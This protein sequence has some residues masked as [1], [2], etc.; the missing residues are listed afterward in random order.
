M[1]DKQEFYNYIDKQMSLFPELLTEYR[2]EID[3]WYF[4]AA[5]AVSEA[6]DIRSLV[7]MDKTLKA[8]DQSTTVGSNDD[9]YSVEVKC[10]LNGILEIESAFESTQEVPLGNIPVWLETSGEAKRQVMLDAQGKASVADLTPGKEY[11][12]TVDHQVTQADMDTLFSH[13]DAI[14]ADLLAWLEGKWQGFKPQWEKYFSTSA[15]ALALDMVASFADGIWDAL[16]ALWD[17]IGELFELLQDPEKALALIADVGNDVVSAIKAA[18]DLA[19]KALLFASDE[20][21]LYLFSRAAVLY[22][23]MLPLNEIFNELASL[24]GDV[25]ANVLLA[26]LGGVVISLVATPVVGLAYFSI[27]IGTKLKKYLGRLYILIEESLEEVFALAEKLMTGSSDSLKLVAVNGNKLG[28][29]KN[30]TLLLKTENV[31]QSELKVASKIPDEGKVAKNANDKPTQEAEKTKCDKDPISMATGEEL[32]SLQDG[33]LPGLLPFEWT[34]LYRTSAVES[35]H[36]LGF[37]WSHNLSHRLSVEGDEIVWHNSESAQIRLPKPSQDLPIITNRMAGAAAFFGG[38]HSIIIQS[39]AGLYYHFAMGGDIN[40]ASQGLLTQ[41][42]DKYDHRLVIGRDKDNQVVSITNESGLRFALVYGDDELAH[43]ISHV[44]L[45]HKK[46]VQDD[47]QWVFI[48]TQISYQYNEAQQLIA[49]TNVLGDTERYR[50]DEQHVIQARTLAGGAEFSW[51]WQGEGKSVRA[52]RQCSNL[53]NIDTQYEW[54]DSSNTVT[55]TNHL[56]HSQV[57][58]HD[59]NARLVKEVDADGGEYLK[60]YDDKGRLVSES[61]PLGNTT[62]LVYNQQ[63]EMTAK[64][65]PNGE[66]TQFSYKNGELVKVRQGKA[67]WQYQRDGHGNITRQCDPMGQVTDYTYNDHGLLKSIRYFDKSE[68]SFSWNLSGE[69]IDETTPQGEVIRYR[70]DILGRLRRRQDSL[71][72]AE[73]HYDL[74]GRLT[75]Q[76]L[77]G[78]KVRH[79]AYNAYHKLTS[80]TDE[81]GRCT[82]YEYQG[83]SHLLGRKIN[84]DGSQVNYGYDNPFNF[85]SEVVNERGERYQIEY[86]PT[87]HVSREL[88]FDGRECLYQYD[89]HTQLIAKTERAANANHNVHHLATSDCKHDHHANGDLAASVPVELRTEYAYDPLGNMTGKTLSDGQHIDYR[90]DEQGRLIEAN[91]GQWPLVY[92]YDLCGRLIEEHQGWASLGYGYD[93]MGRMS[94]MVLPDGQRIDYGFNRGL[95][96]EI[97]LNGAQLSK[98]EYQATGLEVSRQQGA[99]NSRYYHDEQGRLAEHRLSQQ[100]HEKLHRRYHYSGAGNLTKTEDSQ[101]GETQYQYDP[102]DRLVEVRGG[103]DEQFGHDPAGNLLQDKRVNV[104]GNQ[105]LFQG[106][107]HFD[108]DGFGNLIAERRGKDSQQITHYSYDSQHRLI[109]VRKPDGSHAR[110]RYDVYGRRINKTV[111]DKRGHS[112]STDFIWQGDKLLTESEVSTRASRKAQANAGQAAYEPRYQTYLYEYGSFK[113]LAL[114]TGEGIENSQAYFYQLDQLGTPLELTN[115]QG[116]IVWSVS[117][118]AYGNVALQTVN[119]VDNPLRFQGQYYDNETGLHYNRHRYY[120]PNTGRFITPDPIGLAGGLNNY[121]YVKNP[122]GWVDPLGLMQCEVQCPGKK[123]KRPDKYFETRREAFRQVKKDAGIPLSAQA[124][125]KNVELTDASG[126]PML[127]E[128]YKKI[129]T[130]EYHFTNIY[131]EKVVIQEHSL[132]HSDFPGSASE[133]PHFNVREYDEITGNAHRNRTLPRK[134]VALH[135]VFK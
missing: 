48:C 16:T 37:G 67:V 14:N 57:Y 112:T 62:Q 104:K 44:E 69:L 126:I 100:G 123:W 61:D 10:P 78:G 95:L 53:P 6:A 23:S 17:G 120:S 106:D 86:S 33:Q 47:E 76:V 70:Y 50:Y 115:Q 38:E 22:L 121:Q 11:T 3:S 28:K 124:K 111:T 58:Q 91:D 2:T 130:R 131:D 65:A 133:K 15:S 20:A 64:I 36:G 5:D 110:Y 54:D 77:P 101:R 89:K 42:S 93:D 41:I 98:H 105:L 99:L 73:M 27:K 29:A 12:V 18:P 34:R 68:H 94:H 103:I 9:D 56:G 129:Q 63:G 39:E 132:G 128:S 116:D 119:E 85:L 60:R 8:G 135:Y 90:Y 75:K 127:D 80:F 24:T 84:P 13:Y 51:L 49:A 1:S 71:G 26:I 79:Y 74:G 117:Y 134:S 87:G 113:P 118:Q 31:V 43:L 45:Y 122:T 55:L 97:T 96:S 4:N 88:S 125:V 25:L 82:R 109:E 72:I 52:V 19:A 81:Q 40:A 114:I 59:D 66:P 107:S 102:L 83:S 46:T 35:N 21:G 92:R 32:L 30:G 7:G 108:Y